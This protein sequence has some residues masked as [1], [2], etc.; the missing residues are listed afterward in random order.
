VQKD[1]TTA[2]LSD[3]AVGEKVAVQASSSSSTTAASVAIMLPHLGG[4]VVSVSGSTI[5]VAD[6][7]GFY[8]TI[9][10]SSSTTYS[11]SSATAALERRHRGLLR[12][13]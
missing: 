5:T 3:L 13:G 1:R 7:D 10:V 11:K 4:Q 6:R 2:S 8:R 9:V 12:H